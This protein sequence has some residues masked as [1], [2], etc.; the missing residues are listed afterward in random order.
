MPRNTSRTLDEDES[1]DEYLSET[2]KMIFTAYMNFTETSKF[3]IKLNFE[4]PEQVSNAVIE[5]ELKFPE[6]FKSA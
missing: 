1:I 2:E 5:L 4:N 6:V 3:D